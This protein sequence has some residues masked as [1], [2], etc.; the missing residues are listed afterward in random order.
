MRFFYMSTHKQR[1]LTGFTLIELIISIV[2]L[3]VGLVGVL[4]IIPLAQR[5]SGRSALA[6]RA[7]ILASE[8]IEELKSKGYE[9]LTSQSEWNGTEDI[10]VWTASVV[11]VTEDD[12]LGVV[13]LP[14]K[15]IIKIDMEVTYQDRGKE[16][17]EKFITFY[18]EL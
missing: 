15:P 10:F 13:S 16:Q 4:L 6:S 11:D 1:T 5:A 7:S 18:S 12:F 8:K 17:H 2:I 3:I 9:E 14:S